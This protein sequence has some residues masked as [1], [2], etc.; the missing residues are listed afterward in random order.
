MTA[1]HQ[2][3]G[4][5]TGDLSPRAQRI[6]DTLA[7]WPRRKV[8][9]TELWRIL[10]QADPSTRMT[11]TRRQLLLDTLGEL[12]DADLLNLP[13][14]PSWDRSEKPYLPRFVRLPAA[15]P[16][17]A[18]TMGIVWH[19]ALAWVP[20]A[21]LHGT[22]K[23][24]LERVN[25]WLHTNRSDLVVPL[26]ERSLEIFG[27]EKTLDRLLRS[28]LFGPDRLTLDLLRARR[29]APRFTHERVGDGDTLLVVE[30]SDTFDSLCHVLTDRPGN[31]GIVGWGS[32]GGF[33][34]SV[35][36]IPLLPH[37]VQRVLY[38]GDLDLRGLQIPASASRTATAEGLPPVE[39]AVGLYQALLTVGQEQATTRTSASTA[40]ET[41]RWL[42]E[43]LRARAHGLLVSG[44]RVAQEDTG[45][46]HLTERH[47]WRR[48]L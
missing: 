37:P 9:L 38:Y 42:P 32:G 10:D 48:L 41:T 14:T 11:G 3:T 39:P 46:G 12:A 6:V 47:E 13:A 18:P 17:P 21:R 34:A 5:P 35:L 15:D 30:N 26:R 33:E 2:P 31:V 40:A 36:S 8:T 27:H 28:T 29:A 20:E 22:Q 24:D 23:A 43:H 25:R 19:P 1:A 44:R 45:L 4:T 7:D 16:T